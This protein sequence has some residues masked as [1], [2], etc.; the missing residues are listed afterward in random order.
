MPIT[1]SAPRTTPTPIAAGRS[2]PA[3]DVRFGVG[4]VGVDGRGGLG[5]HQTA[6]SSASLRLSSSSICSMCFL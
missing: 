6:S 4:W 3:R 5:G 2:R 1:T